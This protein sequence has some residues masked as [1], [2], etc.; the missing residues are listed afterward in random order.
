MSGLFIVILGSAVALAFIL[1]ALISYW[2]NERRA[3]MVFLSLAVILSTPYFITGL[4]TFRYQAFAQIFLIGLPIII[5]IVLLTSFGRKPNPAWQLPQSRIDERD[6]MFS[7]RLLQPG[8]KE[9]NEYYQMHP[10]KRALD[11]IWRSQPGLLAQSAKFYHPVLFSAADSSFDAV[12]CFQL[13]VQGQEHEVQ[14][15][16]NPAEITDFIKVWAKKSGAM[17]VGVTRLRDYHCYS[18][19]GRGPKYGMAISKEHEFA[20]VLTVEMSYRMLQSAPFGPTVMESAQ[21]YLTSGAIAI[22]IAQ[23][24]RRL[25]YPARAHIDANYQVVCPLVARDAG[26]GEIGRMGLLMT[27]ELGPRVRIAVVSTN[28]P[29]LCDAPKPDASVTDFCRNC[30][31]CADAC[32]A[33]AIPFGEPR[34]INGI[35]RWQINSEACFTYWCSVGTDC[36]RCVRVCPYSHP[37]NI[38]HNLVRAGIR[39]SPLFRRF[40]IK[41]DDVFYGHRPGSAPPPDWMK[42]KN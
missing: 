38:L 10:I 11:N 2:E 19:V 39:C 5:F 25:G 15:R 9:F 16:L 18:H 35:Q 41:M 22:R 8:T 42:F 14:T 4:Y 30:E 29:L 1:G 17:S 36:G 6:T 34:E 7:R 27:P 12:S 23:L 28:L 21:Q 26:L 20:I 32:P 31:K 3:V 40:A 24:I 37:N 33:Q 13:L